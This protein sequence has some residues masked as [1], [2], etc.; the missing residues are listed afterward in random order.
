MT[1]LPAKISACATSGLDEALRP[2]PMHKYVRGCVYNTPAHVRL[3]D[4]L[5]CFAQVRAKGDFVCENTILPRMRDLRTCFL[6]LHKSVPKSVLFIKIHTLVRAG[7]V[8]LFS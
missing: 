2:D 3:A 1:A 7:L 4:L 5:S 6:V 8:D